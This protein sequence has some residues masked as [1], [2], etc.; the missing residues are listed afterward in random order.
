MFLPMATM[1]AAPV[2]SPGR[3]VYAHFK[4][5]DD[6][7]RMEVKAPAWFVNVPQHLD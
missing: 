5:T 3:R 7:G 1:R 2:L 4:T 6:H